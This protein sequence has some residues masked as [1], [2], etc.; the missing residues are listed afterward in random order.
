MEQAVKRTKGRPRQA[1]AR[2]AMLQRRCASHRTLQSPPNALAHTLPR[3]CYSF[4]LT[5]GS[6]AQAHLPSA[7]GVCIYPRARAHAHI[8]TQ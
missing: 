2:N 1:S 8:H 5:S 6:G 7:C 4:L 3:P